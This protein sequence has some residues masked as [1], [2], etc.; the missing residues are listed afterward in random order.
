[1]QTT[2]LPGIRAGAYCSVFQIMGGIVKESLPWLRL[3]AGVKHTRRDA[4]S[5]ARPNTPY[6]YPDRHCHSGVQAHEEIIF[7]A[8]GEKEGHHRPDGAMRHV[9]PL[10]A[11]TGSPQP[12]GEI[13]LL[14]VPSRR[15]RV[16][17]RTKS[18]CVYHGRV[19]IYSKLAPWMHYSRIAARHRKGAMP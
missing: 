6:S 9:R 17:T 1:L 11:G 18:C 5:D 12:S 3:P 15:T 8:A 2:V 14:A 16:L 19:P 13:L 10:P 7:P 4:N